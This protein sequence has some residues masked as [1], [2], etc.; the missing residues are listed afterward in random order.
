MAVSEL[1]TTVILW[2]TFHRL[3]L[4]SLSVLLR[5]SRTTRHW[6]LPLS[7]RAG[8]RTL[9]APVYLVLLADVWLIPAVAPG[10]AAASS[11]RVSWCTA[12][13]GL[14]FSPL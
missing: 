2:H 1:D 8:F 5:F 9:L 11:S 3:W 4:L 14:T 13:T 10:T 6:G 7:L 12:L